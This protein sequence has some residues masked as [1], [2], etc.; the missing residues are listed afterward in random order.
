MS[1]SLAIAATTQTLRTLLEKEI[2]LRD[3]G[4]PGLKVTTLPPDLARSGP[5]DVSAQLNVF[6]Y[7][8]ITNAAWRN[9]PLPTQ[10][11]PGETG[12][13]PLALNLHYLFTA[14]GDDSGNESISHRV[15]GGAMAVMHDHALLDRNRIREFLLGSDLAGSDL[16]E[17]FE[18]LR[19]TPLVLPLDEMSKLWT[20]LQTNYRVST[21]YEV[22][23]VLIDSL[24]ATR[25]PLPVLKRGQNDR[26]PDATASLAPQIIELRYPRGQLAARLGETVVLKGVGIDR[27][28]TVLRFASARLPLPLELPPLPGDA[29]DELVFE[30]P[31]PADPASAD[32]AC[33]WY[34]LAAVVG[35][36]NDPKLISNEVAFALAPIITFASVISVNP[37][38]PTL[39]DVAIT[40]NGV[41][42]C[43]AGQRVTLAFGDRQATADAPPVPPPLPAPPPRFDPAFTIE[44]VAPGQ[45]YLVRLRVDGIDSIPVV[46]TGVPPLPAFDPAQQVD[47]P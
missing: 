9:Q 30:L 16:A 45:S 28:K 47:V 10:A 33:G 7:Q 44:R 18:T 25:A 32:W 5:G 21:G 14:Y 11:R 41:P 43:I 3:T 17:Q 4:L 6:L 8:T 19:A 39:R 2:P 29:A 37:G 26:G 1:T 34:S 35:G 12:R 40:V 15:L 23:V 36:V 24:A 20:A 42:Q 38:D 46:V 22:T 13:P 27:T 31:E